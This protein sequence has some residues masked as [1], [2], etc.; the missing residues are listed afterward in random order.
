[1]AVV[2]AP[3]FVIAQAWG[4][5]MFPDKAVKM[6]YVLNC[7]ECHGRMAEGSTEGPALVNVDFLKESSVER[8]S[9]IISKGAMGKDKRFAA[10]QM[11]A[12]MPGF[13]EDLSK[14]DIG[15]LA[16]LVKSW[17]K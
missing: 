16:A 13:S 14:D 10:S 8:I 3:M 12:E 5:D 4:A 11:E 7:A 6:T 1:M 9:E 2:S 17:N 15:A